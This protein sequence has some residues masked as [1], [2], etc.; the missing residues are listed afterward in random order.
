MPDQSGVDQPN[1]SH[2]GSAT[3]IAID[4]M[5]G[6]FGPAVTVPA[7]LDFLALRPGA[8]VILVGLEDAIRE[9]DPCLPFSAAPPG[10]MELQ[11][12]TVMIPAVARTEGR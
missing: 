12:D 8:R 9:A 2:A 4:A 3:T 5:G 6:D 7:A 1:L 11:V 10:T